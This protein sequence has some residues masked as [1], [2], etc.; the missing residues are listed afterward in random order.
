MNLILWF[1][2]TY[3]MTEKNECCSDHVGYI[4]YVHV[5]E[6]LNRILIKKQNL[7]DS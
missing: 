1:Y 4:I 3:F 6:S 2:E 7:F 5:Y